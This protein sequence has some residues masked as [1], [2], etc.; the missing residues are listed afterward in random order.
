MPDLR[1]PIGE[2]D[3]QEIPTEDEIPGL[4]ERIAAL[5]RNLRDAV[6]GLSD[7]QLATPYRPDG[8]TVAQVVHHL[9]DSHTHSFLR[10][11]KVL[12]E[13]TPRIEGYDEAVWAE[14]PDAKQLDIT[15]SL[16]WL[17]A[18]HARWIDLLRGIAPK[19]RQRKFKHSEYGDLSIAIYYRMY[20]WHSDHHVAHITELRKRE[21]W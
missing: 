11:K 2:F 15:L 4:I 10:F 5:P 12:T 16:N 14:L 21:G 3:F 18:L 6:A 17:D 20:A 19:E 9:A 1:F 13:D 8:W 7:E